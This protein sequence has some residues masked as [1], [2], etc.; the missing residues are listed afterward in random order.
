M[1]TVPSAIEWSI[2]EKSGVGASL[3]VYSLPSRWWMPTTT[4]RERPWLSTVLDVVADGLEIPV[5]VG[6]RCNAPG[7]A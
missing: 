1:R 4:S 6:D 5:R 3:R 7:A 2:E